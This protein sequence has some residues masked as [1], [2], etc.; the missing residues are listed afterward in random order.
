[1]AA[2]T[3]K[4]KYFVFEIKYGMFKYLDYFMI[5][6]KGFYNKTSCHTKHLPQQ[7]QKKKDNKKK[8]VSGDC[9]WITTNIKTDK[10]SFVGNKNQSMSSYNSDNELYIN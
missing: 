2:F 5:H 9:N 4:L 3:R 1:L 7:I 6:R 10:I 8:K